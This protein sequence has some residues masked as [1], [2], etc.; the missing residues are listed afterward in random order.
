MQP[1]R[2]AQRLP[3]MRKFL[4][5]QAGIAALSTVLL[6]SPAS[7]FELV[8][9]GGNT[10]MSLSDARNAPAFELEY[11]DQVS[12]L[13][14][15]MGAVIVSQTHGNGFVG[16]GPSFTVNFA[17]K[18]F[19]EGSLM[20]GFYRAGGASGASSGLSARALLGVGYG[21][22]DD[23]AIGLATSHITRPDAD[24]TNSVTLRLRMNF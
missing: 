15:Q 6:T 2:L 24:G 22:T 17:P 19:A 5:Y 20:G 8:L 3:G 23:T 12:G 16:A 7:A 14:F 4:A 11:H 10:D 18:W 13:P 9:G 1:M 21:L